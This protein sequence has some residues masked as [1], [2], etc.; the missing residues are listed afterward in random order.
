MRRHPNHLIRNLLI[1]S[2]IILAAMHPHATRQLARLG[3][4]LVLTI[5][6]GA[7][8]GAAAHPGAALLLAGAA[9]LAHQIRTHQPRPATARA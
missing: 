6:Q 8:D 1:A 4:E 5:V 3:T 9:Y 2:L 7:A